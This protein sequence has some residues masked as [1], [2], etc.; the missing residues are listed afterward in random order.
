MRLR[1]PLILSGLVVILTISVLAGT[2]LAQDQ[3]QTPGAK[4]GSY[5]EIFLD[6]L[7]AVLG[8]SREKLDQSITQARDETVDQAVKDGKL[9]QERADRIKSQQPQYPMFGFLDMPAKQNGRAPIMIAPGLM[10]DAIAEALGITP[11]ELA[12]QIRSGKSLKELA[13]GKEQAVKDAILKAQKERL[14]QAVKDGKLTQEQADKIYERLQQ[15]DPLSMFGGM[16]IQGR[17][18][19]KH[20]FFS[21]GKPMMKP[22]RK[23]IN[24]PARPG[25]NVS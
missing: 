19:D 15:F 16:K 6:R 2:A 3:P 13:E 10:H 8:V 24:R 14:D 17:A 1:T 9:S 23:S 11:E 20:R 12:N 22:E 5:G 21:P 7:A 4:S 18:F 25:S